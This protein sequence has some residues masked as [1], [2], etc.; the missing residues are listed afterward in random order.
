M[1]E[2]PTFIQAEVHFLGN[3][4]IIRYPRKQIGKHIVEVTQSQ[5]HFR[6]LVVNSLVSTF[7]G[8]QRI[9]MDTRWPI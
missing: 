5:W 1:W 2:S 9:Y 7:S 3:G 8:Q 6:C 4:P